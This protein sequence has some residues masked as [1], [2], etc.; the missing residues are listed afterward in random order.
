MVALDV[1]AVLVVEVMER[2]KML[3]LATELLIL[4]VAAVVHI[5]QSLALAVLELLSFATTEVYKGERYE[6]RN[7]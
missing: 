4:A 3:T 1:T 7:S 2:Q 5:V 6:L